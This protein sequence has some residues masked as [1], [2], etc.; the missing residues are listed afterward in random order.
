MYTPVDIRFEASK[1]PLDVAIFNSVR[2]AGVEKIKRFLQSVLLVGGSSLV[3]GMVH[4][5][6]SRYVKPE[7]MIDPLAQR[8][9]ESTRLQAIAFPL[10]PG[11][12]RLTVLTP[13]ADID[14]R[15]LA[16]KGVTILSKLDLLSDMWVTPG[17][18]VR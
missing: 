3:P 14:P 1:L 11:I 7:Y 4:A 15:V 2:A 12:E 17:E 9:S 13:P 18:W 8:S 16:W 5:L 10:I 6:E